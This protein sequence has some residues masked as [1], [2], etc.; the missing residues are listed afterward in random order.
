MILN[1]NNEF[2]LVLILILLIYLIFVKYA[3]IYLNKNSDEIIDIV[4]KKPNK[5]NM[6]IIKKRS[7]NKI[8]KQ[9]MNF[10]NY[11]AFYDDTIESKGS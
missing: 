11:F 4:P 3:R 10:T 1:L 5:E 9:K 6:H 8:I 2:S 7:F